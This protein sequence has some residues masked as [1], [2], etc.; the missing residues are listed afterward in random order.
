MPETKCETQ[1]GFR[2]AHVL[3]GNINDPEQ[4]P[5]AWFWSFHVF[6]ASPGREEF[7][8]NRLNEAA[9]VVSSKEPNR[10]KCYIRACKQ[11]HLDFL[12]HTRHFMVNYNE[13]HLFETRVYVWIWFSIFTTRS[14]F[15]AGC[16]LQLNSCHVCAFRVCY[17]KLSSRF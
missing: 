17:L 2:N 8:N 12:G 11:A 13:N 16:D 15:P 1:P 10:S 7:T 9:E 6:T 14:S 3:F 4:T 5:R